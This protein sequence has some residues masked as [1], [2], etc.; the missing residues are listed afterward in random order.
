MLN[1]F[2]VYSCMLPSRRT[3]SIVFTLPLPRICS[4]L[5]VSRNLYLTLRNASSN[6]VSGH[7]VK[8][9]FHGK[10]FCTFTVH[11]TSPMCHLLAVHNCNHV[12]NSRNKG[13]W[14]EEFDEIN[15]ILSQYSPPT[16]HQ[17]MLEVVLGLALQM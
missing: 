3:T 15:I 5:H 8:A 2:F 17:I 7:Y 10:G 16:S 11:S 14:R 13:S 4:I 1:S 12:H 6:C 9:L